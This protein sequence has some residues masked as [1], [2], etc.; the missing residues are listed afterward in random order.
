MQ[1]IIDRIEIHHIYPRSYIV[2]YSKVNNR[3]IRNVY[4]G[5]ELE[6]EKMFQKSMQELRYLYNIEVISHQKEPVR[7]TSNNA[8]KIVITDL[9]T[10]NASN[11]LPRTNKRSTEYQAKLYIH[12]D[13]LPNTRLITSSSNAK[14]QVNYVGRMRVKRLVITGVALSIAAASVIT[15]YH[16]Y[17]EKKFERALLFHN[18][19][20][21]RYHNTGTSID[22]NDLSLFS[23]YQRFETIFDSLK[24]EEY[25]ELNKE[26]I[27]FFVDYLEQM[28]DS[29]N[30]N[31]FENRNRTTYRSAFLLSFIDGF[32]NVT[33]DKKIKVGRIERDYNAIFGTDSK[34]MPNFNSNKA[35]EYCKNASDYIKEDYSYKGLPL[36]EKLILL[37]QLRSVVVETKFNYSIVNKPAAWVFTNGY[38]Y[39]EFVQFLNEEIGSI[40]KEI[41]KKCDRQQRI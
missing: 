17:K 16:L 8:N 11:D 33:N 4:N 25:K 29:N 32:E 24:N 36:V 18:S 3:E 10:I 19:P 6:L 9:N 41:Q 12:D 28:F 14:A 21:V 13:G 30:N 40:T 39:D 23:N 27:D 15:G 7:Y 38:N 26:D 34:K 20:I 35:Y 37:S 22:K 5:D 2:I 31:D 1:E